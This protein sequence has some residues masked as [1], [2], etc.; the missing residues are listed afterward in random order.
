MEQQEEECD[1]SIQTPDQLSQEATP[2][3]NVE[4][5]KVEVVQPT[6]PVIPTTIQVSPI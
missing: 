3:R 5:K 6:K 2:E 1:S 4:E